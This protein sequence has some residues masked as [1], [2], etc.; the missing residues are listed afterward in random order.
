MTDGM[1]ANLS[2]GQGGL[3]ATPLQIAS[4]YSA[5]VNRG[6]YISPKLVISSVD[7][8]GSE[9]RTEDSQYKYRALSREESEKMKKLLINNFKEGTCVS[10]KPDKCVAGGKTSTAE[11]GITDENGREILHSWFAGFIECGDSVYTIVVFKED[12]VSGSKDCGPVFHEIADR[13]SEAKCK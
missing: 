12:G 2:F 4:C 1:L 6:R 10:A 13:I 5:V 11:T 9:E 8:D 7:S 3:L